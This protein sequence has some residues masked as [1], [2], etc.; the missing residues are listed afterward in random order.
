[1]YPSTA[2]TDHG[3]KIVPDCLDLDDEVH[4]IIFDN[5][6][7]YEP[8]RLYTSFPVDLPNVTNVKVAS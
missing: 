3:G 1:M 6:L 4:R 2:Y 7:N 5:E 8:V